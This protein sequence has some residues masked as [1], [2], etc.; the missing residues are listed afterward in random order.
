M[1]ERDPLARLY[2]VATGK[3]E[4]ATLDSLR[5][6]A[7]LIWPCE[8]CSAVNPE[9][10]ADCATC[11]ATRPPPP[12][13]ADPVAWIVEV[14]EARMQDPSARTVVLKLAVSTARAW[15]ECARRERNRSHG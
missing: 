14:L 11:G 12:V 2:E 3:A 9:D 4:V 15:I 1:S 5:L 10:A 7:G 6:R 8:D 13:F